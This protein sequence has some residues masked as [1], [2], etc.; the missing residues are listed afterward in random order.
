MV[1]AS[2]VTFHTPVQ[3]LRRILNC[4]VNSPIDRILVID[5]SGNSTLLPVVEEYPRTDY[6]PHDNKG[7]GSGHN[8]ALEYARTLGADYH[9]VLNPDIYWKGNVVGRLRDYMDSD[10]DVGLVMPKILYPDGR[11]QHLCKKLPTP[12][13]LL[14][15]RFV[16]LKSFQKKHDYEYELQWTGYDRLMEVPSL[17]GCFMF[18]RMSVL[19]KVGTFDERYFMYAEDMDLC[20]RIGDVSKTM[21]FPDA[22]VVHEYDK[23]SYKSKKLLKLHIASVIKYFNKWGWIFDSGRNKRNKNLLGILKT[24]NQ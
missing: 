1:T 4:A 11:I 20:R 18:M 19:E 24:S 9:L 21:F 14:G 3:E 7:Y 13:D 10:P 17:S 12:F 8:V 15:R 16:P 2:I 5:H 6:I 23:G 22:T